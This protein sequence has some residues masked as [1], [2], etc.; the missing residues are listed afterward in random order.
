MQGDSET[1]NRLM[2]GNR[3]EGNF[4]SFAYFDGPLYSVGP[5]EPVT[6]RI[7][8]NY[9]EEIPTGVDD[10]WIR[11]DIL[12]NILREKNIYD[13]QYHFFRRPLTTDQDFEKTEI[14]P[15]DVDI[16]EY[17][18]DLNRIVFRFKTPGLYL[19]WFDGDSFCVLDPEDP[20]QAEIGRLLDEA[21]AIPKE[22]TDRET[23]KSLQDW[24]AAKLKYDRDAYKISYG[25]YWDTS[26]NASVDPTDENIAV[27]EASQDA[28]GA[29]A[30][31]TA[32]CGGYSNLYTLLL[33]NAGIP[34]FQVIG[35]LSSRGVGHAWNI[36]RMDGTWLFADPTWDDSGSKSSAKYFGG[37]LE[38]Y[39]KHH[40]GNFDMPESY[41]IGM[42]EES[43]Y[44]TM[45]RRFD[46]RYSVKLEIPDMLRVLPGDISGYSF[47]AKDPAFLKGKWDVSDGLLKYD[48]GKS[49]INI[50][51]S[52]HNMRGEQYEAYDLSDRYMFTSNRYASF[53]RFPKGQIIDFV[54]ADYLGPYKPVNKPFITQE[55][56]WARTVLEE[57]NFSYSV[58]M[59]RN[60]IRG[61]SENSR[62]TWTYDMDM[63][64]KAMTWDLEK[65]GTTL[66]VTAYFDENGKAVRASVM[67]TPPS[68][69]NGFGWETTRDG[70]LT[71]LRV[72][73]GNDTYLLAEMTDVWQQNRH[74]AYR[75]SILRKYP[76]LAEGQPLPEGVRLYR[77]SKDDLVTSADT[78]FLFRPN[79]YGGEVIAATDELLFW[80]EEGHL[81][82]NTDARDLN[83]DPVVIKMGTAM[84][85]SMAV[86][87]VIA[88]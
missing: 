44:Y 32:V 60:E 18:R 76:S 25:L 41:V 49:K 78:M 2:L 10:E 74:E 79:L 1:N 9:E 37:T 4:Y 57:T 47:P 7:C 6:L 38:Q 75:R 62:R 68:G 86:R 34:A 20:E 39:H 45:C 17:D 48:F 65:D 12:R 43:V 33:R 58:P 21:R 50:A 63:N 30:S 73:D 3:N 55:Y 71:S 11:N 51:Y 70:H 13:D 46:T 53:G 61:Y 31:G 59:K 66:S 42:F 84:D 27:T 82:V 22:E 14:N 67:L 83:G 64:K 26:E 56:V 77:L 54:A 40:A 36:V 23:A 24:E 8:R 80:D 88:E 5:G 16:I 52:V 29:L 81:Q 15:E 69:G 85:L 35:Y 72:D 28:F 19:T 87:I